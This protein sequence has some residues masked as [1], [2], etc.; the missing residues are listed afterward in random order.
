MLAQVMTAIEVLDDPNANGQRVCELFD[1]FEGVHVEFETVTTPRGKTDVVRI[2]IHGDDSS[3]PVLGIVGQL[4]G[5]G[6]RPEMIGLV[7]D[8]DG[9]VAALACALKLAQMRQKGEKLAG[10]VFV[11]THVCPNAPTRE[12]RPVPFMDSPIGVREALQLMLN[13]HVD[14]VLSIDTTKGNRIAK[15]RGFAISPTV[16]K[17][18][19]LK[20]SEDLL[21][22]YENVCGTVPFVLPITMQ[23]ITPY[24]NGVY[25]IN[26]IMQPCTVVPDVP[27]V[28]VAITTEVPVAG[29]ATG[30]S[31]EVD[32]E[33]AA[34]FCVEVAKYFGR[35][36]IRFYDEAE[37]EKLLK[38]YGDFTHLATGG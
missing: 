1:G 13:R 25:H 20:V 5:V 3:A 21:N 19:I 12:H 6:A 15:K 37:F 27:V 16:L 4:G 31:H 38:L 29:C 33:L 26:S 10:T 35:R 11:A 22:I 2:T 32:I 30:A 28:G 7:S 14:A 23:D 9:A 34:R 17:G 24:D 36:Q 18:Y 8:A